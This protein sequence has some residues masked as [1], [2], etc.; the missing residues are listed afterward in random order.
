MGSLLYGQVSIEFDDRTLIHI[1][2]VI[3]QKL[4]RSESFLL[5]WRNATATGGGRGSVWIHPAIPL[6]FKFVGGKPPTL[7]PDWL[8]K[9]TEAAN[10]AQGLVITREDAKDIPTVSKL[11]GGP[12]FARVAPATESQ[13]APR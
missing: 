10:G 11:P 7:N 3:V 9:L 13:A 12:R 4:R 1:Q 2:V 8:A 5:S 6:Y